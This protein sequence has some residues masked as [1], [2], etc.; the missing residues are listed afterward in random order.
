MSK[1]IQ[2]ENLVIGKRYYF[3]ES[4]TANGVY[5]G[6]SEDNNYLIFNN[7]ENNSR[8]EPNS[9]NSVEFMNMDLDLSWCEYEGSKYGTQLYLEF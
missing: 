6:K 2:T 4:K 9:D 7:V 3:D 1:I 5:N 8:Y